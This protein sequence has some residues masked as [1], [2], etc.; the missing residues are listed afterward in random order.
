MNRD[1]TFQ[2]AALVLAVVA[3]LGSALVVPLV[4][5]QRRDLQL[6]FESDNVVAASMGS[7]KGLAVNALW[8]R[9]EMEKRAGRYAEANTIAEM[10]TDLQPR[11]PQVWAFHA[12]NMAYNISVATF[13]PRE[14][15]DW[16][17]KGIR[18]L[19]EE[20]LRYNPDAGRL[21][22][23]LGWTWFHKVGQFTDDMNWYYKG[24]V[25][26]EWHEVLGGPNDY[27]AG[28]GLLDYYI[29]IAATGDRYLRFDRPGRE[30]RSAL[31]RLSENIPEVADIRDDF[32]RASLNRTQAMLSAVRDDLVAEGRV[33]SAQQVAD[34]TDVIDE[35]LVNANRDPVAVFREEMPAVGPAIDALRDAGF[36]L[37]A[38]TLRAIGK[39]RMYSRLLPPER[40]MT[41]SEQYLDADARAMGE[42]FFARDDPEFQQGLNTLLPFLRARVLTDTYNMDPEFML[43]LME[44]HGPLDWR[45]PM[46]HSLYWAAMGIDVAETHRNS[47]IDWVNT[48]RIVIHSLQSLTDYGNVSF[49]PLMSEGRQVDLMPEPAFLDSYGNQLTRIMEAVENNE[50]G[51]FGNLR[52]ENFESGH[53]NYLHKAIMLSYMYGS[54]AKAQEYYAELRETYGDKHH[55]QFDRRYEQPLADLIWQFISEDLDTQ[56]TARYF[57]ESQLR[58]A[59]GTGLAYGNLNLFGQILGRAQ[60]FHNRYQSE[61][62]YETGI[63]EQGRLSLPPFPQLVE[64]AYV[65]FM[66]DPQVDLIARSTAY[67]NTPLPLAQRTYFRWISA[68]EQQMGQDARNVFVEPEGAVLPDN[69]TDADGVNVPAAIDRQ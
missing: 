31:D 13:T 44:L 41:L 63:T 68:I 33:E 64:D 54:E 67:A 18:L 66:Q 30:L 19:R 6:S 35:V 65:R 24:Y 4:N 57:F 60:E 10:I 16:V 59:F 14:R 53:E 28:Q 47:D 15:W 69:Q 55:N 20:G 3:L 12:W 27:L 62:N 9:A 49:N 25:A 1:R 58:R 51:R 8:Y 29:A 56:N 40:V 11:F 26:R 48:Y 45:H 34:V 17:H 61:R 50:E 52:V 37:D 5:Q 43:R 36:D 2:L 32:R 22:R 46:A 38:R 39:L 23:E 21:Y 7:F 42:L